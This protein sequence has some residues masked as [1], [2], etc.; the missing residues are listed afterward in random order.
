MGESIP[1]VPGG[2]P[3]TGSEPVEITRD[4]AAW[5]GGYYRGDSNWCGRP[6]VAVYGAQ[7]AASQATLDIPLDAAG[8][9]GAQLLLTGMDD[10]LPQPTRIEITVNGQTIFSGPSPFLNWDGL[11]DCAHPTWTTVTLAIPA[12]LLHAG[13]NQ[14]TIANLE[15]SGAI[16]LPPYVMLSTAILRLSD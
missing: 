4:P 8:G 12:G 6:W 3:T 2:P 15:P 14:I 5:S 13:D 9:G 10:E 7:S 11:D 1:I 16:G